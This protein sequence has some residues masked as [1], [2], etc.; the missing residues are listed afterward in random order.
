M[1]GFSII[2]QMIPFDQWWKNVQV[3]WFFL[4][5]TFLFYGLW[6]KTNR[7]SIV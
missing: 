3:T 7:W 5:T 2:E 4:Y 6:I 1:N